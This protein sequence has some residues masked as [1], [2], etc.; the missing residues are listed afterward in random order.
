MIAWTIAPTIAGTDVPVDI[1]REAA[2]EAALRELA[3]PVYPKESWTDRLFQYVTEWIDDLFRA[4]GEFPG[5]A[6][7]LF[8][9]GLIVAGLAVL[10]LR[11][12]ARATR[13]SAPTA[14]L[15]DERTMSAA[16]HRAAAEHHALRHEW[17]DAVRERL[18]A[19]A[20]DLEERAIVDPQP[21]RTAAEFAAEAGRAMP[22]FGTELT[23]AARYFDDVTYGEA[24]GD[25]AWYSMLTSLDERLR[26]ARPALAA[27]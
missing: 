1:G 17:A 24:P 11:A 9:L 23:A 10:L 21:G 2:R 12:A 20:R 18:R 7:A 15:Y 8:V 19:I 5:G 14:E 3:H 25:P 13:S 27:R 22:A 26:V 6:A 4:A 16:E